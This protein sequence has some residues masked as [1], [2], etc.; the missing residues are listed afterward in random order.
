MYK[1]YLNSMQRTSQFVLKPWH[2]GVLEPVQAIKKTLLY[3]NKYN[4]I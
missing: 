3:I 2:K 4:K 1:T